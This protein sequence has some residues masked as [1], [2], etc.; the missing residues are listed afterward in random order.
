MINT[1]G[2]NLGFQFFSENLGRMGLIFTPPI[3][4]WYLQPDWG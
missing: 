3:N 1:N 2:L 4:P